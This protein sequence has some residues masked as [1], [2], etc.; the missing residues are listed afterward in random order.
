MHVME[1]RDA[2]FHLMLRR[3][4]NDELGLEA[5]ADLDRH[6]A[7]CPA[8]A[9]EA[10]A[11]LAFDRA[12][13]AAMTAVPVPA[14]L[15]DRLLTEALAARGSYLRRKVCRT[16][17]LAASVLLAVG[18]VCGAFAAGRPKFDPDEFVQQQEE[19]FQDP[20]PAI[21]RFLTEQHLPPELPWALNPD[22]LVSLGSERVQGREVPV[23]VFMSP[24]DRGYAKVYVFRSGGGFKL[25]LPG[26]RDAHASNVR[27]SVTEIGGVVYVAVY[28]GHDLRPF[29]RA[30][31]AA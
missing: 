18:I 5:A 11:A 7:G 28:T 20:G 22:L 25:D 24:V 31:A 9:R 3:S 30:G 10:R 17:A 1:C 29:L 21:A 6:L 26:L 13:A 27:A 2:Q 16:A 14:M 19:Q 8:C 15:H 4:A 23:L 12:V